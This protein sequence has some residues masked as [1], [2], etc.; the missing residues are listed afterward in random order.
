MIKAEE[1][2]VAL[3]T[4]SVGSGYVTMGSFN[5]LKK[6]L[7][8]LIWTKTKC[9]KCINIK[10]LYASI[11]FQTSLHILSLNFSSLNGVKRVACRRIRMR[12]M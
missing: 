9:L 11:L 10:K 12:K 7:L 3:F 6:V 5:M 2:K 4:V 1:S 8:K